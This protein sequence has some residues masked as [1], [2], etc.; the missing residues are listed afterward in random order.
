MPASAAHITVVGKAALEH[1]LKNP[2]ADQIAT[3]RPWIRKLRSR[4]KKFGGGKQHVVVQIRKDYDESGEWY[5]GEAQQSFNRRDTLEQ[6]FYR[7]TGFRDGYTMSTDEFIEGGLTISDDSRV[8]MTA[9]EKVILT[10]LFEERN[11]SLMLGFEKQLDQGFHR[12]GSFATDAIR[13]LDHLIGTT[14]TTGTVG[15]LNRATYS[16]WRP[17]ITTGV[18]QANMAAEMRKAYRRC[19]R[20]GGQP[21][22][23]SMG[24]DALEMYIGTAEAA[25]QRRVNAPMAGGQPQLDLGTGAS[26]DGGVQTGYA[27]KGIPIVWDPVNEDLDALESLGAATKWEKRIY[28]VNCNH[29]QEM[30]VKKFDEV[31]YTP[32][33]VYNREAHFFGRRWKGAL[34][35]KRANA[36]ALLFTT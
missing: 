29:I 22:Y 15:N 17:N 4:K 1:Y 14:A 23:I 18:T 9:D 5:Y 33:T 32:P 27:F 35:M 26:I 19:Q 12:S 28:M 31:A 13:G 3:G 2:P 21:D 25:V 7:W 24:T 11:E 34:I 8:A 16:W 6:A 10:N 36:H 20:N 30:P